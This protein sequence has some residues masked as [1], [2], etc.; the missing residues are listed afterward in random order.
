[1]GEFVDG[2]DTGILGNDI[3]WMNA[4]ARAQAAMKFGKYLD[5]WEAH[6]QANPE[7]TFEDARKWVNEQTK[8]DALNHAAITL[9]PA[10]RRFMSAARRSDQAP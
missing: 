7:A 3:G 10:M 9:N 2:P 8:P 1:M 6:H 5:A 4:Q